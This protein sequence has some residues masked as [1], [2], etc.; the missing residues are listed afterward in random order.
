MLGIRKTDRVRNETIYEKVRECPLVQTV[1]QRQLRWLGHALRRDKDEPARIFALYEPVQS[2]GSIKGRPPTTYKQYIS[3]L[4]TTDKKDITTKQNM[5]SDRTKWEK[6][7]AE[8]GKNK[9]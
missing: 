6:R 2:H 1:Q 5:A 8:I 3:G 9:S 7:V 4:L